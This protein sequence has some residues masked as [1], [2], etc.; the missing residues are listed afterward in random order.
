MLG[1]DDKLGDVQQDVMERLEM[2]KWQEWEVEIDGNEEGS[3]KKGTDENVRG[4]ERQKGLGSYEM[5]EGR[6]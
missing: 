5:M 3:G 2:M 6:R 4:V 1:S